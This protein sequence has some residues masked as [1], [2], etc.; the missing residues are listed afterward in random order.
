MSMPHE[1][2]CGICGRSMSPMFVAG[3]DYNDPRMTG[4]APAPDLTQLKA[5]ETCALCGQ[6]HERGV[7]CSPA[8]TPAEPK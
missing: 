3:I 4:A 7:A 2:K 1:C 6:Y 5:Y 8:P